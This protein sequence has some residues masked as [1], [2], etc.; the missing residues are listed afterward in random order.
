MQNND[1]LFD[2]TQCA[3]ANSRLVYLIL[4]VNDLSVSRNFYENMLGLRLVEADDNSAKYATGQT[5]LCLYRAADYGLKLSTLDHSA[6]MTFL[7]DDLDRVRIDLESQGVKFSETLRYEIGATVNFF[8]PDGHWFSLYEPSELAMTWPSADKLRAIL[9][10]SGNGFRESRLTGR[11]LIYL[12]LFVPDADVAFN[13][14]H[15]VLG[16]RYLE[17]RPCRRGSTDNKRGVVKYDAGGLLLTTHHF[18]GACPA[19]SP[20]RTLNSDQM[21]GVTPVFHVSNL[22]N[23]I[24]ALARENVRAVPSLQ[25]GQENMVSFQD[26]FG[27]TFYIYE[28]T[29]TNLG[30]PTGTKLADILAA[31]L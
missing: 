24:E 1:E 29:A 21:K 2:R 16:L 27:R 18:D 7:V 5:L 10:A 9:K 26:P 11:E 6:D 12:F 4:Y 23:T 30:T 8:D 17:C 13:F 14:Y 31:S 19:T 22:N 28:V 20:P 15:D 3:L 25:S